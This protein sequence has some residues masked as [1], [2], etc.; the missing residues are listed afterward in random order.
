LT[1]RAARYIAYSLE[2]L[3]ASISSAGIGSGLDVESLVTK[4]MAV[5]KMPV[6][7]LDTKEAGIDA[8]LSALGTVKSA[9]AAL[10]TAAKALGTPNQLMPA[11]ASVADSTVLGA[12]TSGAVAPGSYNIEV[13]S[14]AESQK[15]KTTLGWNATTDVVGDGTL[16]IKVGSYA[17]G[18]FVADASKSAAAITI[19]PANH[20]LAGIRD[21]INASNAGVTASIIND[22]SKNY[23]SLTSKDTGQANALQ[24]SSADAGLQALTFDGVG[25]ANAQQTVAAKD[26]VIFVDTVKITK[27][28]NTISDAIE[29]VTLNLNATTA[30]GV[31]TKL[32]VTR[33]TGAVKSAVQNLVTAYNAA[34]KAMADATA[35]D[36]STG[37]SAVLNGDS[38]IRSI[39]SQLRSVMGAAVS[40]A[41]RGAATLADVGITSQTDGSL[42]VDDTKLSA[43][44]A[45]PN[46]D[47]TK[48]FAYSGTNKGY[49]AQLDTVIGRILSPVGLLPGH[50]NSFNDQIKDIGKQRDALNLRL[51]ATEKR[52]RAQFSALDSAIASMSSTSNYLTQQLAGLSKLG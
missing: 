15:L 29:G 24:I 41:S 40:G 25:G 51:A 1:R 28:S 5:E 33:D 16:T 27:P 12:S 18:S 52:Y 7:A 23:L 10:Q 14:L 43:A 22:G 9:L 49:G 13:Q 20:T 32:T 50:A 35:Y 44:L 45:D 21:A 37:T 3:M 19:S 2:K 46:R 30:S 39:Q 42:A 4:L 17:S 47:M 26:A 34:A 38:T 48:L 36:T 8:K 6:T 31:T 11:K